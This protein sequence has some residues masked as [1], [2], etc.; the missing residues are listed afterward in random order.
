MNNTTIVTAFFDIN[1]EKKGDGRSIDEYLKW[2]KQ[3]L[4]LNCHLIVYTESK[5]VDFMHAHRPKCYPIIVIEQRLQ[6]L[7]FY[8]YLPRMEKILQ[9][10]YYKQKIADPNRVECVLPAYNIIQHSKFGW[11]KQTIASNPFKTEY[12]FWMDIGA[13]RFFKNIDLSKQFPVSSKELENSEERFMVQMRHD[14]YSFPID[15]NFIWRS[16]NL[17]R[18]GFLGG[19]KNTM[20]K[21]D[22]EMKNIFEKEM[23]SKEN[24]NNEQ[25][26]MTLL[27]KKKPELF[28]IIPDMNSEV[29]LMDL[30]AMS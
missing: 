29:V 1:R 24:V 9:S 30:L 27:W 4:Q 3:T 19:H 5:F 18:G 21:M 17:L 15:E 11:I 16:D 12:F 25:L 22:D 28:K 26:T 8:K 2:I 7:S 10:D 6:D 20:C 14:L 13:S 23:L